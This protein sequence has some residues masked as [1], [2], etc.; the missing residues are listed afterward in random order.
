MLGLLYDSLLL[1][2]LDKGVIFHLAVLF[3]F[4]EKPIAILFGLFPVT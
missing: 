4:G 3:I 1:E 2:E